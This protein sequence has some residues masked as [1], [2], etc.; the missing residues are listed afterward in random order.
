MPKG[1]IGKRIAVVVVVVLIL[2]AVFM[3][4]V[5]KRG[6]KEKI[7]AGEEAVPSETRSITL[8]FARGDAEGVVSESHEVPVR[9]GVD[10]QM[11]AVVEELLRGPDKKEAVS[12]IP[13]GTRV[14]DLFWNEDRQTVYIDFSQSFVS[15]H[16]GGSTAEYFTIDTIIKTIQ[17]NFPQVRFVQFLVEGYPVETIAGHYAVDKPIELSKWR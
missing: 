16:P 3:V 17:T 15:N 2:A 5:G 12:A 4:Y 7:P 10:G 11:K 9:G 6:V 1:N 14:L 13:R 8:F